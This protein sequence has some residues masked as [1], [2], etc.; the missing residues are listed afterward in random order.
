MVIITGILTNI[1]NANSLTINSN[2]EDY[3]IS[4]VSSI[5]TLQIGSTFSVEIIEQ[6]ACYSYKK[7][8]KGFIN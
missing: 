5:G 6:E 8:E 3:Y 7:N 1:W 2:N 4:T